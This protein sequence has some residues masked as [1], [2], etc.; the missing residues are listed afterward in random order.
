MTR[1][2]SKKKQIKELFERDKQL[3]KIIRF[4]IARYPLK[5]VKIMNLLDPQEGV[6]FEL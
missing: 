4:W 3:R 2:N 5:D 1:L 6:K